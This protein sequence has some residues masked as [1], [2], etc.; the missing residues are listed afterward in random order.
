MCSGNGAH[1]GVRAALHRRHMPKGRYNI[2]AQ[3]K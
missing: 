1:K 3:I 2:P